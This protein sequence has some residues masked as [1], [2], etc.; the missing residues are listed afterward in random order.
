MEDGTMFETWCNCA[1][2]DIRKD[3]NHHKLSL[4]DA[5]NTFVYFINEMS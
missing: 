1:V 2:Y 3:V 5:E 4:L